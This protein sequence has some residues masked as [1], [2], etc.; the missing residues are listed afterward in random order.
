MDLR[1]L[2]ISVCKATDSK[3]ILPQKL[4]STGNFGGWV[5]ITASFWTMRDL[6]SPALPAKL[7]VMAGRLKTWAK[8]TQKSS[9]PIP[10]GAQAPAGCSRPAL[11]LHGKEQAA[12]WAA[13]GTK[14]FGSLWGSPV[15]VPLVHADWNFAR[16]GPLCLFMAKEMSENLWDFSS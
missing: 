2:L 4:R 11:G 9:A 14:L 12:A 15:P 6:I 5:C 8:L 13:A 7:G 16:E 10:P 1:Q 3:V